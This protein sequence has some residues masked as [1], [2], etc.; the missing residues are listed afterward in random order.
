MS[1]LLFIIK[2]ESANLA[3]QKNKNVGLYENIPEMPN[4]KTW[5]YCVLGELFNN[6][7][8]TNDHCISRECL[9]TNYLEKINVK[10]GTKGKTPDKTLDRNMQELRDR[11]LIEFIK[12]GEY[13]ISCSITELTDYLT[14]N[15]NGKISSGEEVIK[16]YLDKKKID[17]IREK[18]FPDLKYKSF[19][20]MDFYID[21]YNTC[22]EFD[23]KQH[24]EPVEYFGGVRQLELTQK[25]DEIKN[26]YCVKNSIK[27]VR[28][29]YKQ[30][31]NVPKILDQYF[32]IKKNKS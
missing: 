32:D 11:G 31:R 14:Q 10:V 4:N 22:I 24:Y 5:K 30:M 2:E 12:P 29:N 15:N 7:K 25:R 28:I 13:R 21:K 17:Y 6:L 23:G 18:T 16:R 19:L 20:R 3:H 8:I 9:M 1:K 26:D 27:L